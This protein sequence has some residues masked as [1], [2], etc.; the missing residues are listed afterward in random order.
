MSR[1]YLPIRADRLSC[2]L[3]LWPLPSPLSLWQ[4]YFIPEISKPSLHMVFPFRVA[5]S[6]DHIKCLGYYPAQNPS[7][8]P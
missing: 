5:V 2:P 4:F 7:T 6:Q 1:S 3:P 8:K